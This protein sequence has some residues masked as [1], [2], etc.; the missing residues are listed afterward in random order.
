MLGAI[1]P[2]KLVHSSHC[3]SISIFLESLI[4]ITHFRCSCL[5]NTQSTQIMD[6][7]VQRT[8]HSQR[9]K[10]VFPPLLRSDA[11]QES[12]RCT[13]GY[14]QKTEN[15]KSQ[16]SAQTE[17]HSRRKETL[18]QC[19]LK[20][21]ANGKAKKMVSGNEREEELLKRKHEVHT[22]IAQLF[23]VGVYLI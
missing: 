1:L 7:S 12:E 2:S 11:E 17:D 16:Q 18:T 14:N 6:I 21:R 22:S 5:G 10:S 9:H 23:S 8:A 15:E 4:W 13:R 3:C 20:W 19:V